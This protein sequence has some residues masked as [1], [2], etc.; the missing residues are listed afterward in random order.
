[1]NVLL[2]LTYSVFLNE[3]V[4][5]AL[6]VEH[7]CADLEER[8]TSAWTEVF[9]K[10]HAHAEVRL[11]LLVREPYLLNLCYCRLFHNLSFFVWFMLW[12]QYRPLPASD[13]SEFVRSFT[14]EVLNVRVKF[15]LQGTSDCCDPYSAVLCQF[16]LASLPKFY[17]FSLCH[18][19]YICYICILNIYWAF[20]ELI[21][22]VSLA[23]YQRLQR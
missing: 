2:T 19:D 20:C 15:P 10:V 6:A 21:G 18:L 16:N 4:N 5:V 7:R 1:M 3:P 9:E 11:R 8:D 22:F 12:R 14:D 13:V 17:S 23:L